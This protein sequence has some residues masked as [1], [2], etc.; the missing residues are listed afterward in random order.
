MICYVLKRFVKIEFL[1]IHYMPYYDLTKLDPFLITLRVSVPDRLEFSMNLLF[2][3]HLKMSENF[4]NVRISEKRYN[5]FRF[6]GQPSYFDILSVLWFGF[7]WGFVVA[8]AYQPFSEYS[9][10]LKSFNSFV[11][12]ISDVMEHSNTAVCA[13]KPPLLSSYGPYGCQ[14]SSGFEIMRLFHIERNA[15]T[16]KNV[17]AL[18]YAGH[19][20]QRLLW[21]D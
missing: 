19:S 15:E 10:R 20:L 17:R 13:P 3:S 16:E 7:S 21:L 14:K 9:H 8:R 11:A 1:S 6:R 4:E 2:S 18:S 12:S 5:L